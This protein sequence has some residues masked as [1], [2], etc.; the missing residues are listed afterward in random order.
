MI[1][2]I[3]GS[4]WELYKAHWQRL[5]QVAF[6]VYAVLAVLSALLI[7]T[8]GVVGGL[9]VAV[10]SII[11]GFWVQGA[12]VKAVD[13]VRDGRA[14]MSV[15]E[16]FRSV[17]PKIGPIAGASILAGIAIGIGL[18]LLIVPGLILLT[19]WC[20][21]IPAIVLENAGALESFGRSR[22]LVTGRGFEVFGLILVTLLIELVF[23]AL[24]SALLQGASQTVQQLISSLVT[25]TVVTPFYATVLT[26]LYFRLRDSAPSAPPAT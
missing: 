4:S 20:V 23:T 12:L 22:Q 17:Q 26:L 16:T 21:I 9:L 15:G 8:A 19:I 1:S 5:M 7:G 18:I 11:G 13:D 10:I 24:L 25:G 6:I 14:D 3:L 2:E